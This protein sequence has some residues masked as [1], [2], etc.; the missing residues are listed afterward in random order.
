MPDKLDQDIEEVLSKI[1]DFEWHRRQRREPSRLRRSWNRRWDALTQSI[2]S[3]LVR[4][5]PGHLMLLG[6]LVLL[7]ALVFR[8]RGLGTWMVLAGVVL[9]MLGLVWSMRGGGGGRTA[10]GGGGYWRDRYIRY[11]DGP[12][13]G[14]RGWFRRQL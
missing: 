13:R 6:F 9:F 5:T 12:P 3:L 7:G 10:R 2:A 11:E 1:E 14:P 4:F 8:F